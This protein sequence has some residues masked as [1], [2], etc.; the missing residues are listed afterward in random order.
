[1][2][3]ASIQL[4][5][6]KLSDDATVINRQLFNEIK[7]EIERKQGV[8]PFAQFMNMALYQP[9]LGYYQN[10]LHKFGEKGDFITAPETGKSFAYC[11]AN[12]IS[13]YFRIDSENKS[14]KLDLVTVFESVGSVLSGKM[15][16]NELEKIEDEACP[17]CGSCAGMFTAN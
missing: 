8:I 3:Q 16:E 15:T 9:K 1:M 7:M 4:E 17:T 6:V 5:D 2:N 14:K 12:S 13:D 10:N 11:L